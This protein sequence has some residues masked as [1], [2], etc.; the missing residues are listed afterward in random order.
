MKIGF[1]CSAAVSLLVVLPSS[2]L[3]PTSD[4]LKAADAWRTEILGGDV[5]KLPFTFTYDGRK[6]PAAD[7]TRTKTA[8]GFALRDPSGTVEA[9]VE[10]RTY[11]GSPAFS[12]LLGFRNVSKVRSKVISKVKPLDFRA[13]AASKSQT[14]LVHHAAGAMQ[15]LN[16]YQQFS[17]L[18]SQEWWRQHKLHVQTAGGRSCEAA[19]PYFNLETP[20]AKAGLIAA[21]G[22]AGQWE[23][24]FDATGDDRLRM[25]AGMSDSNFCLEP[26][27]SLRGPRAVVLLYRRGD[28]LEGQNLWRQW[29]LRFNAPRQDG[30]LVESQTMCSMCN[31]TEFGSDRMSAES[32]KNY[33]DGYA[34]HGFAF[35]YWWIDAAWY[36]WKNQWNDPKTRAP[37]WRWT[38][39]WTPD[40]VRFPKGPGEVFAYAKEKCGAKGGILWFETE[41]AVTSTPVHQEHPDWFY[42]SPAYRGHFLNWSKKEAWDWAFK[43]VDGTLR[44]EGANFYRQDFNFPPLHIWRDNDRR[45]GPDRTGVSE[46]KHVEALY[47]FYGAL[48]KADPSRRI[49]NCAQGGTRNDVE[50]LSYAVPLWRTDTSG[51][52]DEQ[53][54]QTAGISLW[55]PLY[56]GGHPAKTDVYELRS[57]LQPYLHLGTNAKDAGDWTRLKENLGLWRKHCAPYYAKDFYPLTRSDAGADL[58]CAWEFVDA[59]KGEGFVQAFRRADA[60]S[61]SFLV[62]PRGLDAATDYVF[63]DVDTHETWT[64][65]GDGEFEIRAEKPRTAKVLAFHPAGEAPVAILNDA[66]REFLNRPRWERMGLMLDP[67]FRAAAKAAGSRPKPH[68]VKV[69]SG[70]ETVELYR[71]ADRKLVRTVPVKD[72]VAKLDNLEVATKYVWRAMSGGKAVAKGKFATEDGVPRICRIDGTGNVRDFGGRVMADGRRVRQ[73]LVYRSATFNQTADA[74]PGKD[75]ANWKPGR[76]RLTEAAAREAQETF[77]FRTDLDL[78]T[79]WECFGMEGSPLG[80][81]VR[82]TRIESSNYGDMRSPKAREAFARCF[83]T[84]NDAKNLPLVFHC[85]GGAD[86]T[87]SLAWILGGILGEKEEDLYRDWE[88]TVFDYDPVKFNH[89]NFIGGLTRLLDELYP[90]RSPQEQCVAYA[91]DCGISDDEIASFRKLMLETKGK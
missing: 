45:N 76:T 43:A 60:T 68:E 31:G 52:V 20:D 26:G 77:G 35:D 46:M 79:D 83:R 22:W 73:G 82:W 25:T 42:P 29:F 61:P 84:V 47:R 12:W 74:G 10:V 19:W 8:N 81:D 62:R 58:W 41:N 36:Q 32:M 56:G 65:R 48:L 53:Q 49:D 2:A 69:A 13:P 72:G 24:D 17:T 34:A 67:A 16:D 3:E 89:W 85:V 50:T 71:V 4:E 21:I 37:H 70:T 28:W 87:G 40:P 44:R 80:P 64:I 15:S 1:V 33:I 7:W 91:K 78:R 30:R 66:M 88:L 51:P 57:R 59:E 55:V 54:M 63:E 38:G 14:H 39:N 86:R 9:T 27:E 6:A 11:P 23:A 5:A 90:K 75:K 18:L